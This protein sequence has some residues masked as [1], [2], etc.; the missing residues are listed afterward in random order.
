MT[1][2]GIVATA[3]TLAYYSRL[4]EVTAN[5]LANVSTDAYKAD[6]MTAY[7]PANS[8][9]PVAVSQLDLT[10]GT[11]RET[12]RLLDLALDGAGFFVVA[13]ANGERLVRGGSFRLDAAGRLIDT[14][15][16]AVLGEDGPVTLLG[17]SFEVRT[18]GTIIA[19]GAALGRLRVVHPADPHAL[20]KEGAGRF[21]TDGAVAPA[22]PEVTRVRQGAVEEANLDAIRGLVDLVAIQRAYSANIRA[23]QAMD[24]VLG[25]IANE[26]AR[27]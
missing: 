14:H 22:D 5:N 12:S 27:P 18:D 24:G 4:E 7:R 15:G 21:V 16:D 9:S 3:R 6:R 19:D 26:I 25:T 13:T 8:S 17:S 23:L 11:F 20:R 1:L 2:P 10:Q